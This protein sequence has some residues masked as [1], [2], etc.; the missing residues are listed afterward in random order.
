[1]KKTTKVLLIYTVPYG[2]T[3]VPIGL[4]SI[5]ASLK[6]K[7]HEVKIF[8]T[9]FYNLK[10]EKNVDKR[11]SQIKMTKEIKDEKNIFI[12]K[13]DIFSDI[14][15]LI[16]EYN[17]DIIGISLLESF[18]YNCI[19]IVDYIKKNIG[20]IPIVVG[21]VFPT[22]S[23]D[24]V[25]NEKSIDMICVGEGEVSFATLCTNMANNKSIK[26]I[27]GIWF[28]EDGKVIKNNP[29]KLVD[30]QSLP[31]PCFD[32]FDKRIFYKPMQGKMYKMVNITT[33][34]G[35]PYNCSFCAAPKLRILFKENNC[36]MYYRRYSVEKVIEQIH[37]QLSKQ[38]YEFV[39]FS[40][41]T[42]LDMPDREFNI[43]I[44]EYSKIKLPFWFQTRFETINK[45]RIKKLKKIGMFWLTIGIEHGN[46]EFRK[47]IL[48]RRYSNDLIINKMK[49]LSDCGIGV[50]VNNIM[51]FPF[52]NRSLIFDTIELNKKLWNIN[53]LIECNI[54]LFTPYHGC[55]LRDICE[56]E[57]MIDK[58]LV[59]DTT[60]LRPGSV[61]NFSDSFKEEL[62]GLLRT[63]NLYVKLPEKYYPQIRVAE[64]NSKEGDKMFNKLVNML[65]E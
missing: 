45:E 39:Y 53:N 13:E 8:D 19:K 30:L 28:K 42:F 4:S 60:Q 48:K 50:S 23:P 41:E 33:D 15:I 46:E 14:H 44:K 22:V 65:E 3:G 20:D 38:D 16:N 32:D 36:G 21:G 27:D 7:G 64:Q 54:Y 26:N 31:Y 11:R 2:I 1:M 24:I 62:N 12:E 9:V 37:F 56:Q 49:I 17:P 55:K 57:K 34:R 43:F 47:N 18:F 35:C 61:L 40:S 59:I 58:D 63:F 5:A 25:I 51:G 29:H 52:E 10:N 6:D